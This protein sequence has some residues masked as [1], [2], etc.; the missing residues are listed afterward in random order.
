MKKEHYCK[1]CESMA[2]EFCANYKEKVSRHTFSECRGFIARESS[3]PITER[4]H[5]K[6]IEI[7]RPSANPLRKFSP[8]LK[9]SD[10]ILSKPKPFDAIQRGKYT[11]AQVTT[12]KPAYGMAGALT[13]S[14]QLTQERMFRESY[15]PQT[16]ALATLL[17]EVI[18][19]KLS[20]STNRWPYH[21]RVFAMHIPKMHVD[22]SRY[23]KNKGP[24]LAGVLTV[25]TDTMQRIDEGLLRDILNIVAKLAPDVLASVQ[26][27]LRHSSVS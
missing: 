27:L 10:T 17:R 9:K 21:D 24:D 1:D 11:S 26:D 25:S 14:P 7:E 12:E 5:S 22:I 2:L 6:G 23:H 3:N 19:P 4:E 15:L 8:T 13:L 20:R 16:M 18:S